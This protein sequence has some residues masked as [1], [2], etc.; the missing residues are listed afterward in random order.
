MCVLVVDFGT[1][2]VSCARVRLS[3]C[4]FVC[5]FARRCAETYQCVRIYAHRG[6]EVV[7]GGDSA[8]YSSARVRI[9][10]RLLT[11]IHSAHCHR[12]II[13]IAFARASMY[14]QGWWWRVRSSSGRRFVSSP[15]AS[16]QSLW[17]SVKACHLDSS[18]VRALLPKCYDARRY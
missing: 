4:V 10:G 17:Y 16:H 12:D 9:A 7:R 5:V 3:L 8:V 18:E 13:I 6:G 15:T 2:T 1:C 11:N 14:I